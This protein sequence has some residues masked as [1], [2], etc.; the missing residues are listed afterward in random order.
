MRSATA[1]SQSIIALTQRSERRVVASAGDHSQ[2]QQQQQHCG[3]GMAERSLTASLRPS[4]WSR[5]L[6]PL[7][8]G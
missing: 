2:Q 7:S 6:A 3:P 8:D 5:L 4:Q 1:A